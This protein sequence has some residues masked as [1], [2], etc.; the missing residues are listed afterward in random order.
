MNVEKKPTLVTMNVGENRIKLPWKSENWVGSDLTTHALLV[1]VSQIKS[2]ISDFRGNF[3]SVVSTR[4][5]QTKKQYLESR[6]KLNGM[7][8]DRCSVAA[9]VEPKWKQGPC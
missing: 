9:L 4:V 2:E 3:K 1:G 5:L 7:F 6:C 8:F